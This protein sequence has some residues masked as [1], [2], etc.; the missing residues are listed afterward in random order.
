MAVNAVS[1]RTIDDDRF[2]EWRPF[3]DAVK[4]RRPDAGTWCEVWTVVP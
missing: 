2:P 1:G 3:A 4:Q